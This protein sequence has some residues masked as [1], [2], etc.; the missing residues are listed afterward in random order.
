MPRMVAET[1]GLGIMPKN[2]K[3]VF[4]TV[5][6][7]GGD[8]DRFQHPRLLPGPILVAAGPGDIHAG[9]RQFRLL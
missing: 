8:A 1:P 6:E 5:R 7:I 9:R 2:A 3:V 4:E